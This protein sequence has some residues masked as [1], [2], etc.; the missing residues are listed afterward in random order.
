[1]FRASNKRVW[2]VAECARVNE[3]HMFA[4]ISKPSYLTLHHFFVN[5]I[6]RYLCKCILYCLLPSILLRL[7]FCF[8]KSYFLIKES[9]SF[10]YQV[11]LSHVVF[12]RNVWIKFILFKII[13]SY[14][15]VIGMKG[16]ML[17]ISKCIG[18]VLILPPQIFWSTYVI[19]FIF[20][21][22]KC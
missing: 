19:F 21:L 14:R 8:C 12:F 16:K 22:K 1:M 11:D 18:E 4:D 10:D 7:S 3:W 9:C 15:W 5:D 2:L 20:Y 13:A 6:N 17:G